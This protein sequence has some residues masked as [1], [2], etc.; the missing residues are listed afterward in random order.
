ML[1]VVA[2][3]IVDAESIDNRRS[4]W[5]VVSAAASVDNAAS[6]SMSFVDIDV[7]GTA[8]LNPI[9]RRRLK[10]FFVVTRIRGNKLEC[11]SLANLKSLPK[12]AM[13]LGTT[14]FSKMTFYACAACS[15]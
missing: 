4:S 8:S 1:A 7:V 11:F 2:S 13:T 10:H 9:W 12:G 15:N 3:R 14:T 5:N 6:K